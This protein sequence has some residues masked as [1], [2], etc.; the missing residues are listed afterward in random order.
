M[1]RYLIWLLSVPVLALLLLGCASRDEPAL[2]PDRALATPETLPGQQFEQRLTAEASG[3]SQQFW[4]VGQLCGDRFDLRFLTPAGLPLLHVRQ[5]G[6]AIEAL[7]GRA[8]PGALTAERILADLQ[9][10]YWPV[11][12]L[13]GAWDVAW[14]VQVHP[15]QRLLTFHDDVLVEVR[16]A[17]AEQAPWRGLVTLE[18]RQLDYRLEVETLERQIDEC[19]HQDG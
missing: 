6:T 8:L 16:Y 2:V 18:H 3:R 19:Q 9:L 5:Q 17:E 10:V 11:Q 1:S 13:E 7:S 15:R 14:A 4:V 12:A